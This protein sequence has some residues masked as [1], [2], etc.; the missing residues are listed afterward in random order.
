MWCSGTPRSSAGCCGPSDVHT[1]HHARSPAGHRCACCFSIPV[2]LL[3]LQLLLSELQ[4][5]SFHV[6]Q[7]F[8]RQVRWLGWRVAQHG[9]GGCPDGG[10]LPWLKAPLR[11]D[12]LEIDLRGMPL[13]F[14]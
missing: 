3:L 11:R 10:Q 7:G 5:S 6:R 9:V 13:G 2:L 8:G 12:V 1:L 14:L 4:G